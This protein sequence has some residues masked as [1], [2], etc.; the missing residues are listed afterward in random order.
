MPGLGGDVSGRTNAHRGVLPWAGAVLERQWP[1]G[2]YEQ[3]DGGRDA[4]AKGRIKANMRHGDRSDPTGRGLGEATPRGGPLRKLRQVR[5]GEFEYLVV[6]GVC[7]ESL[8]E[9]TVQ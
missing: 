5:V 7:V 3:E 8:V 6:V 2:R 4:L 9:G 1:L